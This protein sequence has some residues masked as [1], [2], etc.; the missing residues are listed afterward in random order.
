MAERV[1]GLLKHCQKYFRKARW[2]HEI[3][4]IEL[5]VVPT[6]IFVQDYRFLLGFTCFCLH[7]LKDAS[8]GFCIK[9]S[10]SLNCRSGLLRSN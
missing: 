6:I 3:I 2:Q 4:A 10:I 9:Y 5:A 7:Q 1:D 8:Y